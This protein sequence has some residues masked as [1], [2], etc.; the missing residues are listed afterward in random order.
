MLLQLGTA[1]KRNSAKAL[2]VA[3]LRKSAHTLS[4]KTLADA[5]NLLSANP[6]A[7]VID[8]IKNMIAKLKE[9]AA[10]EAAHKGWCDEQLKN[11]KLKRDKK[12]SKVNLLSAEIEELTASIETMGKTIETLVKE[13]AELT[14]AVKAATAQREKENAKNTKTIAEAKA[15]ATAVGEAL[16]VLKEFYAAQALL[17]QEGKQAPEMGAYKGNQSGNGGVVGMLEVIESDFLR[18]ESDTTTA[19]EE[20]AAE[21]ETF[22]ADAEEDKEAKHKEE[23]QTKLDKDAAE[24]KKSQTEK[25]LKAVSAELDKA[26]EYYE[27]LKPQCLEVKVSYEERVAKRKEEIESLKEAYKVLDGM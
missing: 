1:S 8:M 24:F 14:E 9:E 7:K 18:L 11:N 5:A 16:T 13:Q 21:F 26:N 3:M 15:G 27:Y 12:T 17:L 23:V 6:F 2:A 4:S 22:V 10:E 20:G 25:D 19:E